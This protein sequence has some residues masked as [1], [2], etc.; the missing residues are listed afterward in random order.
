MSKRSRPSKRYTN[1]DLVLGVVGG[2]VLGLVFMAVGLLPLTFLLPR[3]AELPHW[4]SSIVE[5]ACMVAGFTVGQ[6]IMLARVAER[7]RRYDAHRAAALR[8]RRC[9]VCDYDLRGTVEPRCP[10]CGE[11]FT[12]KEWKHAESN[13]GPR[14]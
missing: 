7:R 9:P 11:H 14:A 3:T 12:A 10:E 8:Q 6:R 13:A 5:A 1:T 2:F 4:L